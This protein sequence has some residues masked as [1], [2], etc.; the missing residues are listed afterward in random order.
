ML[1]RAGAS[2]PLALL[3]R[4]DDLDP[5]QDEAAALSLE[6]VRIAKPRATEQCDSGTL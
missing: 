3:P 5:Q 4:L 6:A 2:G 1:V